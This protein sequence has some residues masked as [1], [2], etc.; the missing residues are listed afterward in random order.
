MTRRQAIK[1]IKRINA[2]NIA[3]EIMNY[4]LLRLIAELLA[5]SLTKE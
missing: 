1:E 3:P 5:N 2:M 4:Y